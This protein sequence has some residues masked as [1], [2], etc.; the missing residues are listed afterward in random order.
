LPR[1][2]VSCRRCTT[3]ELYRSLFPRGRESSKEGLEQAFNSL[4]TRPLPYR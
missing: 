1:K 2:M 4:D 3:A